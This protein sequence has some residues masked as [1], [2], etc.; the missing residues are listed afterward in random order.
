MECRRVIADRSDL[1]EIGF[2]LTAAN[3]AIGQNMVQ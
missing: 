3:D 1:E 2:L